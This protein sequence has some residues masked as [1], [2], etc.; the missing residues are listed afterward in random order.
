MKEVVKLFLNSSDQPRGMTMT[1]TR[2]PFT[3]HNDKERSVMIG[4]RK[5]Y[6]KKHSFFP[7]LRQFPPRQLFLLCVSSVMTRKLPNP[8][9]LRVCST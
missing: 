5:I 7:T 1:M 6:L 4:V 9:F 8:I 2:V 3:G